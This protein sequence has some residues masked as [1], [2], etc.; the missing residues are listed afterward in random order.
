MTPAGRA[1]AALVVAALALV[2]GCALPPPH[3]DAFRFG[4]T[5]DTPYSAVEEHKMI[6]MIADLNGIDLAFI[7]HVGDIKAGSNSPCTDALFAK[8]KAQFEQSRNPFVLTPGDNEWTDCRRPSNGGYDP[9]ERLAA[10]RRIFY[11]PRLTMGSRELP[12]VA[13][14]PTCSKAVD[15]S[16]VCA[17]T[18]PENLWWEHGGVL[19]VTLNI[20]GSNNNVGFDAASDAEAAVRDQANSALLA[21]AFAR[22]RDSGLAGLGVFIQADPW[23]RGKGRPFDAFLAQLAEGAQALR[24]PV[25]FVHGDSHVYRVDKPFRD[26]SGRIVENLTRLETFGSPVVGWVNV[27]VDRNDPALFRIEPGAT[28]P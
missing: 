15:G 3:P 19:F 7:V 5:G 20:P 8:R 12:G 27:A 4:V 25:L 24:K 17:P 9:L 13:N 23:E 16:D 11:A 6:D 21:A 2:S 28:Y 10:L 22:V 18:Y 1:A 26:R 14:V